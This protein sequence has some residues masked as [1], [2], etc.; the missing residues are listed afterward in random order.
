MRDGRW[1]LV[2]RWLGGWE[3]YDLVEDRTELRDLA[4]QHP[5]RVREMVALFDDYARHAQVGSWPWVVRPVRLAVGGVALALLGL[6]VG[7]VVWRRRR[8]VA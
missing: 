4:E 6:V 3:L 1:K 7:L 5:K 8:A 2:S